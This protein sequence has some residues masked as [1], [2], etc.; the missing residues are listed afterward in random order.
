LKA[1]FFD[2]RFG[3]ALQILG[4]LGGTT[5]PAGIALVEAKKDMMTIK[6]KQDLIWYEKRVRCSGQHGRYELPI[7]GV[8]ALANLFAGG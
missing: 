5:R 3:V 4:T 7:I 8:A 2:S 6:H 1:K